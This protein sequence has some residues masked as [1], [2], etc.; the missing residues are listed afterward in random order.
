MSAITTLD[1]LADRYSKSQS[2]GAR[3][4]EQKNLPT[5]K[6]RAEPGV[7]VQQKLPTL[8]TAKA[9][10]AEAIT[11]SQKDLSTQGEV[12]LYNI[13]EL[14]MTLEQKDFE[15]ISNNISYYTGLIVEE[16]N[17][18]TS[19][20]E[21]KLNMITN[22]YD[23]RCLINLPKVILENPHNYYLNTLIVCLDQYARNLNNPLKL[24]IIREEE[25]HW[26]LQFF[27]VHRVQKQLKIPIQ[28]LNHKDIEILEFKDID[29]EKLRMLI[30]NH[31]SLEDMKEDPGL[32]NI[33]ESAIES[34]ESKSVKPPP[35]KKEHVSDMSQTDKLKIQSVIASFVDFQEDV[36]TRRILI[37]Q[38]GLNLSSFDLDA[39]P[40]VV[41]WDLIK[42]CIHQGFSEK[43]SCHTLEI[44]FQILKSKDDIK[45]SQ[46]NTIDDLIDKYE[47][48]SK[49][50]N[51]N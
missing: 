30:A 33:P 10:P 35:R 50:I 41:A 8:E 24:I 29:P 51:A 34:E 44:L 18:I 19:D 1:T 23:H 45:K 40:E 7:E 14:D 31:F 25:I 42:W 26:K 2:A 12:V 37:E 49:T 4:E 46:I 17:I 48:R 15:L 9:A 20:I 27:F 13:K 28:F 22:G 5:L 21:L 39:S 36:K 6:N 47:Y 43:E 11:T 3:V 38:I 16:S 32:T